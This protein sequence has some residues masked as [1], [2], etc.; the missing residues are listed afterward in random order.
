M[1]DFPTRFESTLDLARLPWFE[2]RGDRLFLADRSIGPLVDVHTHLALAYVLPQRLDLRREHAVTEHYLPVER[3]LDLDV[4][5]NRNFSPEDLKRLERDL[6]LG[7]LSAGGMRRTHTIPNLEREMRGLGVVRS[8]L[9][10]IDFPVLSDNAGEWLEAAKGHEDLVVF[11]S[12][13]P[14]RPNMERELRRQVALGARGIKVHPAVQTVLPGD[15]RAMKLYALCARYRLPVLFHCGPVGIE[16]RLGRRLSQVR[17]YFQPIERNPDT[18]F[19]LGHSGALQMEQALEIARRYP[20]VY[21]E[22]SSQSLTNVR[23]ILDNA[24]TDR[25]LFGS[26][27]PFYHQAIPLAKLLIATVG[28]EALR[29]KVLHENAARLLGLDV[30][31]L[32][33]GQT[34]RI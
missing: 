27:W 19:V 10:A 17:H 8:V 21:L 18:T 5:A 31:A 3:R 20:N 13:H 33:A 34:A 26:D 29:P 15:R 28:R 16:T 6:A 23:R 22:I 4:Y 12:V 1:A 25:V 2:R 11:G 9:L 14:Y 32:R 7:S 24:D 30:A